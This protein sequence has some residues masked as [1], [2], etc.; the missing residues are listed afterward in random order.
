M[1]QTSSSE[2]RWLP[3]I[4]AGGLVLLAAI[5]LITVFFADELF[6]EQSPADRGARVASGSGCLACHTSVSGEPSLNPIVGEPPDSFVR[7][8]SFSGERMSIEEIEQWIV[9]GISDEKASSSDH[10]DLLQDRALPMPAYENRL[11]SAELADLKSYVAL[12]QYRRFAT[13]KGSSSRGEQLARDYACFT[14]HGELGQGGVQNPGSLKGYIPGFF[15]TDFRALTRNGN[16]QDIREWIEDGTSEF[17]ESQ[18]FAG[19]YPGQFFSDRQAI[20]MPAYREFLGEEEVELLVDFLVDLM[21]TGP[22][23]AEKLLE[24][25]PVKAQ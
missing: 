5:G 19:F 15:G 22:L 7:V 9:N 17:L 4:L 25:R 14:C 21:E 24:F 23:D 6:P 10:L 8:P 13:E 3:L 16:R 20:R 11:T 2:I 18:G 12:T 1:N